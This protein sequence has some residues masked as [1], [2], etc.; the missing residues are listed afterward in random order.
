MYCVVYAY[1]R[2]ERRARHQS[3]AAQWWFVL[4]AEFLT[5]LECAG[6]F[7]IRLRLRARC[8][9]RAAP[10]AAAWFWRLFWR[11]SHS[12]TACECVSFALRISKLP[13]RKY[14]SSFA[15]ASG[16]AESESE[17]E[18]EA[19]AEADTEA[20]TDTD[21]VAAHVADSSTSLAESPSPPDAP[22]S[23][24]TDSRRLRRWRYASSGRTCTTLEMELTELRSKWFDSNRPHCTKQR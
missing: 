20:D 4:E 15:F 1:E 19:E 3:R 16:A 6:R 17:S 9:A 5:P 7:L 8:A 10:A 21:P 12:T 2:Y 18:T 22:D 11:A 13:A 24:T 14:V 23:D